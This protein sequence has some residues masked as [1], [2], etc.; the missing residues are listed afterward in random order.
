MKFEIVDKNLEN[1]DADIEIIFVIDKNLDHKWVKDK[2]SLALLGYKGEKEEV[3]F[4]PEKRRIYVG[5]TLEHDEIRIAAAKAIKALKGKE[6]KTAKAGVYI[7][8]CPITNIKAFVEG[9]ILGD[10][11]FK[12]YKSKNDKKGVKKIIF[13]NEEYNDK[14]F[15]LEKAK[16]SIHEAGIVA[17][18]TN[19]VRDIVNT[20]PNEIYPETFAKLAK[21]V[22]KESDLDIKILD[23]KDLEKEGMNAF[24]AV[25][26][27]S[28]NPPRL[29]HLSY[30]PKDA[31]AKIAIVG[32]GLTY[33]SGGLSLKPSDYMVTMKADK[34]GASA[35]LGIIKAARELDLPV[36]VHAIL[37][38]AENMIGG[39]AYKPDDILKAKNGKTIEVRNTDAEG[40]LVL[41]D[42]LCY[43]QEKVQPDYLIDIATL[44]GACVVALGE[45]T[46]GVMGHSDELK[47]RF[48]SAAN[49]SGELAGI[50]PFNRYL[51]KLLE[52]KIADICNISSSR[53]G[54]AITAALFLSEFIEEKNKEKWIHLDIAGPAYVE[55]E[56]GYN[57][58]GASGAGVRM[59]IKWMQKEFVYKYVSNHKHASE[60]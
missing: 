15:T 44:T 55:K 53:Y 47:N 7:Q 12:K 34:S 59:V 2:E 10:Y 9:A 24:L 52:S 14:S 11:E 60:S 50:L 54:G 58:Y 13:A 48:V 20:P 36:E 17:K 45:Y 33:D 21:E 16:Q 26:R 25:A 32:K 30:K 57:P 8:N 37:G 3:A 49:S 23:E 29:V 19:L 18:A 5:T 42:C 56:W 39:N 27:A 43:V 4:L 41:A 6:F 35:A 38:L 51:P 1:I 40:R 46:T 28:A 22:A 31:K